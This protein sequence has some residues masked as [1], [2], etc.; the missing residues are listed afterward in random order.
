MGS[1]AGLAL[2]YEIGTD[3]HSVGRP[4]RIIEVGFGEPPVKGGPCIAYGNFLDQRKAR[5]CGPYLEATGTADEYDEG[6]PDPKGPGFEKNLRL[7]FEEALAQGHTDIEIDNPDDEHFST[8]DVIKG[9]ELAG[10]HGLGVIAKNPGLLND[11]GAIQYVGHGNV[12]GIVIEDGAGNA[13]DND[14]IRKRAGKPTLPMWFVFHG[15]AQREAAIRRTA[16]IVKQNIRNAS[17]TLDTAPD[18]YGGDIEHFLLPISSTQSTPMPTNPWMAT[19]RSDIGKYRDGPDVPMLANQ[20]A[21]AFPDDTKLAAYCRLAGQGTAWCGIYVAAKLAAYGIKPPHKD[22]GTGGFMWV[23]AWLPFGTAVTVGQ[24]QPG[25]L[26]L[27]ITGGLHHISFCAGNGKFI[28]G[29]QS[30]SVTESSFPKPTEIRRPPQPSGGVIEPDLRPMLMRDSVGPA[31]ERVQTLLGIPVDGEYGPDTEAAV[32]AFQTTRGLEVDG[33]VGP[34]TWAALADPTPPPGKTYSGKGSWYSQ[35][36]GKHVWVD[37]GDAPGSAALGV[38]DDA[39]GVA[40]YDQATLGKWFAVTAP[41]G[42]TSIE[43]QTDIGPHPRTGRKIDIAACAA[44]RFGYSPSNFPTDSIFSWRAVPAPSAV[45]SLTP[46]QQAVKWRD[47]R[48]TPQPDPKP[49]PVPD[50]NIAAILAALKAIDARLTKLE[51]QPVAVGSKSEWAQVIAAIGSGLERA[52]E[53]VDAV[54]RLLARGPQV[55]SMIERIGT[56]VERFAPL[57]GMFTGARFAALP[58]ASPP[59]ANAQPSGGVGAGTAAIA[60]AGGGM[61][62]AVFALELLTKLMGGG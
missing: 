8:A 6:V 24:E 20:V 39:Q 54:D 26:A 51:Q 28:G 44:E 37:T 34:E 13:A 57:I 17:V 21:Q 55:I 18:E 27:W 50:G 41:N 33:I 4:D 3:E 35:Y 30:N 45:A 15:E 43:Q 62:F 16:E 60:G 38:P 46:K 29:N 59:P 12:H 5:E 36:K 32:R 53:I 42:V 1:Y 52:P 9:I 56:V 31:V 25:D 2:S 58:V 48:G 49:D 22:N 61:G 40:F 11:G 14:D 47:L 23:D 7:Q 10:H 19:V